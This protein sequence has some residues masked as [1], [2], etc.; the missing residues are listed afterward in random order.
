MLRGAFENAALLFLPTTPY[1]LLRAN[2]NLLLPP[3]SPPLLLLPLLQYT[4]AV[5]SESL[6]PT[7]KS[8][9]ALGSLLRKDPKLVKILA[10]PTLSLADKLSIVAELQ[11]A[12]G[13]AGEATVTNFLKTLADNNRLGLLD[14]VVGKFAELIRAAQ[15]QVELVVTS[16]AAL[17]GKTLA[18]LESAVAKSPLVGTGKKLSVKNKVRKAGGDSE[19]KPVTTKYHL[20]TLSSSR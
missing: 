3:P 6:A 19:Q 16:A 11:K 20:L 9:A 2:K 5:K 8:L 18:R 7:A 15:G 13:T 17:D 4:A 12:S 1:Q 14:G 10:T